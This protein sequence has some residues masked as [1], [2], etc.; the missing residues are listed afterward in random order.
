VRVDGQRPGDSHG[1]DTDEDG[2]GVLTDGRLYHLL[3]TVGS[4]HERT[5]LITFREP[6]VAAYAFT[7]G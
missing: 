2:N 3:R 4:V 5:L 6:D 1:V 7:F